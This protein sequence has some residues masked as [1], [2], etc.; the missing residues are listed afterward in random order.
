M[1][2]SIIYLEVH[3]TRFVEY[4]VEDGKYSR[5]RC[6]ELLGNTLFVIVFNLILVHTKSECIFERVF[7]FGSYSD[8]F[9]THTK[10]FDSKSHT[11][12]DISTSARKYH[13]VWLLILDLIKQLLVGIDTDGLKAVGDRSYV[14]PFKS[15]F[16]FIILLNNLFESSKSQYSC[17]SISV[18]N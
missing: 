4:L 10:L 12:D 11:D 2:E 3:I 8:D 5:K 15:S 1:D 7:V 14:F 9:G 6:T 16:V 13:V 17:I 18:Y